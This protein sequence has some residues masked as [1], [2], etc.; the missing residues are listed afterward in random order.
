MARAIF[1]QIGAAC[2]DLGIVVAGG[3][4]EITPT[5]TQPV[6]AGT[7]LGDVPRD[8]V[9]TTG[10]CRPGDAILLAGGAPIE[11][12]SI[13]AR[14]KR[15]ELLA[16][17]WSVRDVDA[18][19]AYLH[20]PGISVLAPALAAAASGCVHAMHDPTEG[21]VATGLAELALAARVG[22]DIDLDAIPIPDLAHDLCAA[23]G[24]DPLGVI[25]SGALLA[26]CAPE[27]VP[28]LLAAWQSVGR[29]GCVIGAATDRPGRLIARRA[30]HTIP[31]PTFAVDEITKLWT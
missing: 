23:F 21:G 17:G 19:A 12:T 24:L 18:A 20:N 3:H 29:S 6:I 8:G 4:S 1:G 27:D 9:I 30:G 31:F 25:A 16:A 13:I 11:G 7:L 10:G 26:A 2:R 22:L 5:V 15:A 14:E 28:T